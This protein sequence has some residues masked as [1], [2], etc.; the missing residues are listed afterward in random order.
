MD[1]DASDLIHLK[2]VS[3]WSKICSYFSLINS[4]YV[5]RREMYVAIQKVYGKSKI[6][7]FAKDVVT[8]KYSI[9]TTTKYG[10]EYSHEKFERENYSY[11]ITVKE[12]YREK[13]KVKQKQVVM[14][15]FHWYQ[16]IDHYVYCDD[17]FYEKLEETFPDKT[18][19]QIN[20][21]CD[22]INRKVK[23]IEREECDKWHSSKEYKVHNKHLNLI[24]KYESKKAVFDELY[25]K[26]IFEQIYDIHLKVMNQDLYEQLPKIRAEKKKADE[27]KQE[28]ERRSREEQQKQWEKYFKEF[29][30]DGSYSIGS[31]SNYTDKEK[32]FL[33]KF[34]RVLATK[35]HP[36]VIEDN[37]PMQFLNKLKETWGI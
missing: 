5:E 1:K 31:S 21:V 17:W 32:E 19:E 22:E 9:G 28:Y 18:Q 34:Y 24:Q 4:N 12:S 6:Y 25:G 33:K 23:V 20:A 7:G 35:F 29:G 37:E 26:D 8:T 10:W 14:G 11:K 16:F 2:N 27:E 15:T 3:I 30:G 13:G 36:D